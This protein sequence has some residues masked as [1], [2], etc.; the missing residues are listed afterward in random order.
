MEAH[1]PLSRKLRLKR[2]LLKKLLPQKLKQNLQSTHQLLLSM[3]L[4]QL[5][6]L[7]HLLQ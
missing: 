4:H 6:L 1:L 3:R 7:K 2:H 5:Q